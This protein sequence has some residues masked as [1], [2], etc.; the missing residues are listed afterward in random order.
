[1]SFCT[2]TFWRVEML[3][4]AG[5][6]WAVRSA[7]LAGAPARGAMADI[8]WA[9]FCATCAPA[10]NP[11]RARMWRHPAAGRWSIHKHIARGSVLFLMS[12]HAAPAGAQGARA[13]QQVNWRMGVRFR[14][15][16]TFL[17]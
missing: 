8:F 12:A 7:K 2:F 6:N 5:C 13:I 15:N 14:P 3:T 17:P 9:S 11:K 1:L 16:L 10:G 4:T